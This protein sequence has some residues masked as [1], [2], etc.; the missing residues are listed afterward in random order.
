MESGGRSGTRNASRTATFPSDGSDYI[1]SL[2]MASPKYVRAFCHQVVQP[3]LLIKRN[4]SYALNG[5]GIWNPMLD[6]EDRRRF[7]LTA[8]NIDCWLA[9]MWHA[10]KPSISLAVS[11]TSS[12]SVPMGAEVVVMGELPLVPPIKTA[13]IR[14]K[15]A[16]ARRPEVTSTDDD[17]CVTPKSEEHVLKPL[18]VCPPAPK[19]PKPA[20]RAPAAPSREF[21]A[22]P[23]DLT[24]VFLSLPPKKRIRV[25]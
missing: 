15:P 6:W 14:D 18:L 12:S 4:G 7:Q 1:S 5:G 23:R 19:K 8:N 13:P 21:C 24:S 10:W 16:E 11:A 25:V 3:D 9:S 17:D 20:R 22:V 2:V